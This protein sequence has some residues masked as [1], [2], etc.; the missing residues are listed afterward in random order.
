MSAIRIG[1]GGERAAWLRVLF[2]AIVKLLIG[3]WR[4]GC[5]RDIR[6]TVPENWNGHVHRSCF[7]F[8]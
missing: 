8:M 6:E 7:D 2:P 3:K 4:W 5:L 1:E